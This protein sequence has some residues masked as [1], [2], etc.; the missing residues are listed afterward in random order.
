MDLWRGLATVG[1]GALLVAGLSL[2]GTYTTVQPARALTPELVSVA[3]GAFFLGV[4]A[5]LAATI[6][7]GVSQVGRAVGLARRAD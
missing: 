2:A 7:R 1:L 5:L 3:Y 4:A 6:A